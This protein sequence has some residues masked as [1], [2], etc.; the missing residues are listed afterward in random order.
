[1]IFCESDNSYSKLHLT[2]SQ[3]VV[4]SRSIGDFEEMLLIYDF[5]RIHHS[6]IINLQHIHEYVKGEGGSV[7]MSDGKE[8][9]V[10]R[11][12]KADLMSLIGG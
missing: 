5:C 12:R 3:S 10:S 9:D 7:V 6:T 2:G 4:T 11:R 1:M 8:L